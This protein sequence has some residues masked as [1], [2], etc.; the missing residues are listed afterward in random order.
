MVFSIIILITLIEKINNVFGSIKYFMKKYIVWNPDATLIGHEDPD[1]ICEIEF[2]KQFDIDLF[3]GADEVFEFTGPANLIKDDPR[4]R[5]VLKHWRNYEGINLPK[6][7]LSWADLLI[8][9]TND[10]I[11]GPW[12]A[13]CA[14][15]EKQYNC[16]NFICITEGIYN[17]KDYPKDRVY[18]DHEHH[19]NK[20]VNFCHFE[21]WNDSPTKPK[22]FDALIGSI[23]NNHIK[24]HRRFLFGQLLSNKLLGKSFINTWGSINFRSPELNKLDDIGAVANPRNSTIVNNHFKNGR[25]MSYSIPI[26]VYRRSWYSLVAETMSEKSNYITEKTSKPLFEK[27]L[28]VIFGA[29]GLLARLHELGYQTFSD[30]ID[31]SYDAEPDNMK[32]W[33]M[34]FDQV[35]KLT[36]ADHL[37]VYNKIAPV[38]EHNHTWIVSQQRNRLQGLKDF[39]GHHI[40]QL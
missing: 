29:Q 3:E 33:N 4:C 25:S 38:L 7:D 40:S 27:R 6:E 9:Y 26:E 2:T 8:L 1:Y 24:A 37:A 23:D 36:R 13:Y 15:V 39:I 32:R 31:E 28:F 35:L 14:A 21:D 5:V 11:I 12:D 19:S 10:V 22:L 34:A 30:V 20:I 18:L 17:L 16:K